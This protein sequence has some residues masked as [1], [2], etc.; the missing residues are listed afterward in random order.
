M[1]FK[2]FD[3]S[4]F[5]T[6][7]LL[8]ILGLIIQY[9]LSPATFIKQFVFTLISIGLFFLVAFLN[10]RVLDSYAYIFYGV[11]LVLLL[12]VLFFGQ[13]FRGTRGWLSLPFFNLYFQP[14]E[15]A[16]LILIIILAKF[17]S[18]KVIPLKKLAISILL[19][20][21][22]VILIFLQPD[23]GSAF[24][25]ILLWLGMILGQIERRK[26]KQIA[27]ITLVVIVVFFLIFSSW[28][29]LKDYQK[30]R[31]L[32]FLDPQRDPLGRGYQITQAIIAIG[33]GNFFGRGL[34]LGPQSQLHFLP[35]AKT[36]FIFSVLAEEL[37]FLGVIFLLGLY[38][39]LFYRIF[40]IAKSVSDNFSLFLVL[41]IGLL[42]FCQI[43]VNLSVNLGLLPVIGISL[44]FLSYGGSALVV[45]LMA[46]GILESVVRKT[47]K[48]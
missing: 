23:F 19:L 27:Q 20:L 11:T 13:T 41:G 26:I 5:I 18:E 8:L 10:Y 45:N 48:H 33:S 31:M 21:S 4:L 47:L 24:L 9:G 38:G 15:I 12:A 7:L 25:L 37:G 6:I 34:G 36:D 42:L 17:Y 3:Y 29:F 46:M 39:L 16:K 1:F 32:I 28:F 2:H 30:E 44:P 22:L 40:R 35:E 43:F 14:V